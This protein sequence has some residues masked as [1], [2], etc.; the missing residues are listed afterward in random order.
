MHKS[1]TVWLRTGLIS[2][3]GCVMHQTLLTRRNYDE[4]EEKEET[5]EKKRID[6]GV[7]GLRDDNR[8]KRKWRLKEKDV[9][10]QKIG[11]LIKAKDREAR[12]SHTISHVEPVS[13]DSV[14]KIESLKSLTLGSFIFFLLF[15]NT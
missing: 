15:T 6:K 3:E 1:E 2:N 10:W 11:G 8:G 13:L 7:E 14:S 9:G 12:F 4:G 5:C